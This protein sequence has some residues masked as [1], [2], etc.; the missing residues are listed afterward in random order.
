[1][2]VFQYV[3]DN[4]WKQSKD[5]LVNRDA[6]AQY[7]VSVVIITSPLV[8]GP[9]DMYGGCLGCSSNGNQPFRRVG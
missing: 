1:M 8:L 4:K 5:I 7:E 3:A 9:T 2:V 6:V